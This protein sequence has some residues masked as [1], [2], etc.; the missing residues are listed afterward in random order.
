MIPL[1]QTSEEHRNEL[2]QN[3]DFVKKEENADVHLIHTKANK[4]VT[5]KS[6]VL[7]SDIT[8]HNHAKES[9]G[10]NIKLAT[11]ALS[12]ASY[13]DIVMYKVYIISDHKSII[14]IEDHHVRTHEKTDIIAEHLQIIE[15]DVLRPK[16]AVVS[17][18]LGLIATAITA[19]LIVCRLRVVKRRGRCGHGPYAHDADYLVNGMYL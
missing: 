13:C 18:S 4:Q 3:K 9:K 12:L 17:L 15:D 1:L 14:V 16:G 2:M 5:E 7:A 8:K 10:K 11:Y 19:A 6:T